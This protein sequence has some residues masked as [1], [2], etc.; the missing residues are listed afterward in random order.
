MPLL[1]HPSYFARIK[2]SEPM[3]CEK[4]SHFLEAARSTAPLTQSGDPKV[5]LEGTG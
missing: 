5:A 4:A 1:S 3:R 2:G